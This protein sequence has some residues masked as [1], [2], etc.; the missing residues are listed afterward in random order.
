MGWGLGWEDG[1]VLWGVKGWERDEGVYCVRANYWIGMMWMDG[2]MDVLWEGWRWLEVEVEGVVGR[3]V[4]WICD[5]WD[6]FYFFFLRYL[7]DCFLNE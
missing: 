1:A 7:L 4:V 2:W 5:G 3:R 6:A